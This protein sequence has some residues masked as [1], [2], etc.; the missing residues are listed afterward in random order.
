MEGA[1]AILSRTSERDDAAEGARELGELIGAEV[2][3]EVQPPREGRWDEDLPGALPAIEAGRTAIDGGARL[4]VAGHCNLAMATIPAMAAL[5]PGLRV[6]W[7][8]AHPDLNT[9]D[10]SASG[11]L[12]GM[13][14]AAACGLWDPGIDTEPF[15]PSRVHLMGARDVDPGEQDHIERFG[16]HYGAPADGPVF[17]HLDLDVL[18]PALMPA[19]FPVEDGWSWEQLEDELLALPGVV[20]IE[21]TGN[22][23][24]HGARVAELLA[25]L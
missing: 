15:D 4:L 10:T 12:G 3:G 23:V 21:I 25:R 11:F 18:D 1:V 7:F 9:P 19:A 22:A 8:D 24:G 14:L 2:V 13:P 17:V 6:A 16:V 5:H 20:G